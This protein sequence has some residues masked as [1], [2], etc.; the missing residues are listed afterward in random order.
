VVVEGT[1]A[2]A[3]PHIRERAR[4]GAYIDAPAD[5]RLARKA[6]RK[7][8]TGKDPRI[9]LRGYLERGR[10]AHELHV[11]PT[12]ELADLVLDGTRPVDELARR[13]RQVVSAERS[14]DTELPARRA[15]V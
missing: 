13:L 6:L 4:W 10:A 11:A 3:L 14:I 5:I 15:G 2:L 12:R 7:I 9:T 8:E 1:F